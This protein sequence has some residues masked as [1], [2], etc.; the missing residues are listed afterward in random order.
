MFGARTRLS[1][2]RSGSPASASRYSTPLSGSRAPARPPRLHGVYAGSGDQL[3]CASFFRTQ[4]ASMRREWDAA[5]P[6]VEDDGVVP[7]GRW[8]KKHVRRSSGTL[9]VHSCSLLFLPTGLRG[10]ILITMFIF[11]C[12]SLVSWRTRH[13]VPFFGRSTLTVTSLRAPPNSS[14]P[15]RSPYCHTKT[16]SGNTEGRA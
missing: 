10:D 5:M 14:R 16:K 11:M 9:I 1:Q 15:A 7:R 12:S 2:R 8:E 13:G 3:G 4:Q 6:G